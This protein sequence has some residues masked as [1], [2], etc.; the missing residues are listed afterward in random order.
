[1]TDTTNNYKQL[2]ELAVL[3]AHGLLE[4]IEADL[5]TRSFHDAPAAIQDEIIQMQQN[6]ASDTSLLPSDT[7]SADLK[8]KVLQSVADAADQE[9]R[10]LAPLAL[11]GA[12]ASASNGTHRNPNHTY[13]WRIVALILFGISVVLGIIAVD[14]QRRIDRVTQMAMNVDIQSTISDVV[15][16]DFKAFIDNPYCHVTRLERTVGNLD[17][18]LRVATNELGGGGFVVGIDLE[19]G[20]E[21][22]IQGTTPS[23]EVL[24]LAR[25]TATGSIA[26]TVFKIDKALVPG[27]KLTAINAVTGERWV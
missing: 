4:P 20:E 21:I 9:A 16:S 23:G 19:Q 24:E 1:M 26:G 11:I 8:R 2:L 17:G 6:F 7:P 27:L 5:F 15:G 18:Y 22:I 14:T 3:D 10:R 12:R 13:I 25:F